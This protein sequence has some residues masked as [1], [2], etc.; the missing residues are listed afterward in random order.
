MGR[1][2]KKPEYLKANAHNAKEAATALAREK[3]VHLV[4]SSCEVI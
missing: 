4:Q 2:K 1:P 3:V